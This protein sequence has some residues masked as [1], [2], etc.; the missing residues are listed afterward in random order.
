MGFFSKPDYSGES[1]QA[2]NAYNEQANK[3]IDTLNQHEAQG[4]T[5]ITGF[6]SRAQGY[7][8]PYTQVGQSALSSY[9]GSL[10]LGG[11]QANLN[12]VNS[13]QTS[14]G[15]QFA[16]NEALKGTQAK[17][18]ATGST[19]SGAEQKELMKQSQE[20]A[21]QEYGG[22]QKQLQSLAG[23]GQQSAEASAGREMDAGKLLS[24]QGQGY[25][26]SLSGLYQDMGSANANAILAQMA[27]ESKDAAAN[28]Q[29]MGGVLGGLFTGG[30]N[31]L[32]DSR[33]S[34]KNSEKEQKGAKGVAAL[35]LL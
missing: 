2:I 29:L 14:L 11:S 1:N 6:L 31:Y 10:G 8:Q 28:K 20:Y 26:G 32:M 24:T 16:V 27:M 12:A 19:G 35:A 23:M 7:S 13:F 17:G 15:Y 4:R 21:N 25:A 3:G 33:N 9:M 5:D 22:W 34:S 18:A 30:A